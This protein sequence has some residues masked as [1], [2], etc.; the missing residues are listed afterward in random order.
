[1]GKAEQVVSLNGKR[2]APRAI[3]R[4]RARRR[5]GRLLP[6]S[7]TPLAIEERPLPL[8][9][10]QRHLHR[11][12]VDHLRGRVG[13]LSKVDRVVTARGKLITSIR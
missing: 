2:A 7:P 10:A 11:H 9:C 4:P 1:M 13:A 8:L 5:P 12:G 3:A 6:S